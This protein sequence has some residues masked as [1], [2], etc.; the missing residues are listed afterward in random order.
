[1]NVAL[2]PYQEFESNEISTADQKQLIVML[3]DG[4]I[5]FLNK[6]KDNMS[7][8]TYDIVNTNILKAQ[9]ILTELMLSLDVENGGEIADNLFNIYSFLKKQL[10]EANVKKN[11]DNIISVISL[12]KD[13]RDAWENTKSSINPSVTSPKEYRSFVAQG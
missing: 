10:I 8:E 1:M 9:D 4:A 13:L 12:M 3:Y 11:N 7:F 6:A 5:R 2:N